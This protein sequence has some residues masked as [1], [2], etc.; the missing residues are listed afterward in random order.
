[1]VRQGWSVTLT[2]IEERLI[3]NGGGSGIDM[4]THY[5]GQLNAGNGVRYVHIYLYIYM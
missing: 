2:K 1:M 3:R 5:F 4:W